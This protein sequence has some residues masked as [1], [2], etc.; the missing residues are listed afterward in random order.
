MDVATALTL[1]ISKINQPIITSYQAGVIIYGLYRDK[2]YKKEKIH[3][4]RKEYPERKDFNKLIR[5]LSTQGILQ[6]NAAVRSQEIFSLLGQGRSSSEEIA[7]SID[8]FAYISHM[9]AMEWHGLTDRVPK[10][11]F[12]SSPEPRRWQ[13][14]AREKMEKDLAGRDEFAVYRLSGMPLLRRLKIGK[15]GEKLLNRYSSVHLGAFISV[16]DRPLRVSTIGRTFLDMLREP[17]LC[18]GI[19]HVIE[20]YTDHAERYLQLIVNEVD[21][22]GSK[23]DK[24]RVGY[25][26]EERLGLPHPV[27]DK[28]IKFAQR[29]GSRKLY[30]QDPYSTRY[31]ER[32]CLSLN[33]E[34]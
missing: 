31:S 18:G 15:I 32:W 26:L 30:A 34:E 9:S 25:L 2:L 1:E 29:G 5:K 11:L 4:I 24:V 28:W 17:N 8:P 14:F 13:K 16:Q 6:E 23:I 7:C 12:V 22:H 20:V 19:Y 3:N 10:I 27:I 33:I 21:R